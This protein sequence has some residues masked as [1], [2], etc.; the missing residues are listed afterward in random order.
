MAGPGS[1]WKPDK[2]FAMDMN[3]GPD[4]SPN[5]WVAGAVGFFVSAAVG[6]L[7]FV[8]GYVTKNWGTILI[9]IGLCVPPAVIGWLNAR[10]RRKR[11]LL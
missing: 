9:A 8:H 3:K 2:S 10:K 5:Q 11:V 1:G 7:L 6:H 4:W